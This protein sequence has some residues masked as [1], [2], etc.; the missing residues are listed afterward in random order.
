MSKTSETHEQNRTTAE[1]TADLFGFLDDDE[2]FFKPS[3]IVK[4]TT[5][6]QDDKEYQAYANSLYQRLLHR[7]EQPDEAFVEEAC[8][9]AKGNEEQTILA[10]E[11]TEPNIDFPFGES[12]DELKTTIEGYEYRV[13]IPKPAYVQS[14]LTSVNHYLKA[15]RNHLRD[16][17]DIDETNVADELAAIDRKAKTGEQ[18]CKDHNRQK[19]VSGYLK[20]LMTS[21]M[22]ERRYKHIASECKNLKCEED[23]ISK[24]L[25]VQNE[26]QL[27][28]FVEELG[29][30]F[31]VTTSTHKLSATQTIKL[32][33]AIFNN[34]PEIRAQAKI[35]LTSTLAQK[36]LKLYHHDP[37]RLLAEAFAEAR[38]T[39]EEILA[40]I[41]KR[42][43][44]DSQYTCPSCDTTVQV[45]KVIYHKSCSVIQWLQRTCHF[46]YDRDEQALREVT[47]RYLTP[48]IRH[49][50]V[51]ALK[52]SAA[53]ER[54]VLI[55]NSHEVSV[56]NNDGVKAKKTILK[57]I[58]EDEIIGSQA[59][60]RR[61][62]LLTPPK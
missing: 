38:L 13:P 2:E 53:L 6:E 50:L 25:F 41:F 11:W 62:G 47:T 5:D 52:F 44:K 33:D 10:P 21:E 34:T 16:L 27:P 37:K 20:I 61:H 17:L 22:M 7:R 3:D 54:D 59:W 14:W 24:G 56:W 48:E 57:T 18:L 8:N 45:S 35:D 4:I 60:R 39:T 55:R 46:Q 43:N 30:R 19:F 28:K 15:Q 58:R 29:T 51:R 1:V 36:T 40:L 26:G 9:V 23:V 12:K 42:G 32:I 31:V 49:N